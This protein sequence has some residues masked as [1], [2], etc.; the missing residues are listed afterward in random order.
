MELFIVR[1][2]IAQ[3]REEF[4]SLCDE[5]RALTDEGR[6]KTRQVARALKKLGCRPERIG[7]SPLRRA[8]ETARI[9]AKVICPEAEMEAC[10]FLKPGGDPREAIRWL[11]NLDDPRPVGV[12][13]VGHM[14]DVAEL[15]GVLLVS[16]AEINIVFKK[17]G[18]CCISFEGQPAA[19]AGVLEWLMQPAQMQSLA[20]S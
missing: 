10:D 9:I 5:E 7:T 14:P 15:A 1:H 6:T 12:M 8:D 2:G 19:G 16:R 3:E 4:P 11:R 13:I 17:A 20:E 18:V